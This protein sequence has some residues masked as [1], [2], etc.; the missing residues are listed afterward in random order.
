MNELTQEGRFRVGPFKWYLAATAISALGDGVRVTALPLLGLAVTR[1]P[2]KLGALTAVATLP[3]LLSPVAGVVADKVVRRD[4]LIA[5]DAARCVLV[6]FLAVMVVMDLVSYPLLVLMGG[7]LGLGEVLFGVGNQAMLPTLVDRSELARAGGQLQASNLIFRTSVGQPLGGFLFTMGMGIPFFVDSISFLGGI[8][9]LSALPRVQTESSAGGSAG[10]MLREGFRYLRSDS[11]MIVLAS[12]LGVI[13]LS[14]GAVMALEA[15]FASDHLGL[16]AV[17]Y[18]VF[19]TVGGFGGVLGSLV[20]HRFAKHYGVLPAAI[21]AQLVSAVA[22]VATGM[23]HTGWVASVMFFCLML[24][25][26][27]Y[28]VLTV[29]L[30]QGI[31]PSA[32]LGRVNGSFRLVGAG[33][34]PIGAFLGGILA[35]RFGSNIPFIVA[36]TMQ[37]VWF[38]AMLLL[39]ASGKIHEE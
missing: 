19:V 29:A 6:A 9:C 18:S 32:M 36:G 33:S 17:Q 39:V 21:S 12:S 4:M 23:S 31:I 3:L 26:T 13:N 25:T 2:V 35:E 5:V 8:F 22:C 1:D 20:A 37:V 10:E 14:F 30:R 28:Q 24:G 38:S 16:D 34:V 27:I 15:F 7:M 11:L